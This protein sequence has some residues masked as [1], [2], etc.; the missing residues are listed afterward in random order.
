MLDR[1]N[2]VALGKALANADRKA[3]VAYSAEGKNYSYENL[4]ETFRNELNEM[5]GSPKLFAQN[6]YEMFSIL[7]EV[8]DTVLP[9]TISVNYKDLAEF[10]QF[11]NNETVK[12]RRQFNSKTRAKQFIT[13]VG[14]AGRYEV[15]K[16]AKGSESFDIRTSAI[17]AAAEIGY[18]E[19]LDGKVDFA[20][21]IDIIT[22]GMDEL[23]YHEIAKAMIAGLNQLPA[24]NKVAGTGFNEAQFDSLLTLAAAYGEPTIY[25]T[26]E[27]AVKMIPQEAWRYTE[28]M[29]SEL[30][31]TGRLAGYKGHTVVILEQGFE[32][33]SLS[34]K[35]IDPGY[36]WI[37]PAGANTK[38]IKVAFQGGLQM[39]DVESQE[40]WSHRIEFYQKVGVTP[41][42]TNDIFCYT[43]STLLGKVDVAAD[44]F[45]IY[46]TVKN[47]VHTKA[48]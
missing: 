38:P 29:K 44:G 14:L 22:E 20:E 46:D 28:E 26:N 34:T 30:Y 35:V 4:N 18:E 1:E 40:D 10:K 45:K 15:F 27:F 33:A 9:K 2:L 5:V 16:L 31:R 12:F 37:I 7:E 25:C 43:D 21:L 6:K 48:L 24:M 39:R 36:C 32:D 17:G 47:I 3:P 13:R 41:M 8:I 23:I 42:F 19:F 11:G